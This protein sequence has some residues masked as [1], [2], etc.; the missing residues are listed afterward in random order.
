[1]V[2][3]GCCYASLVQNFGL[4]RQSSVPS[5]EDRYDD[6]HTARSV[7]DLPRRDR[8]ERAQRVSC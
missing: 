8:G 3:S 1:M 7:T 5:E 4:I 6:K 2:S